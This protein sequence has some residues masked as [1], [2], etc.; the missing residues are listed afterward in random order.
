MKRAP[1]VPMNV[2]FTSPPH[3]GGRSVLAR[4]ATTGWGQSSLCNLR[5]RN[6]G[7]L[8]EVAVI[9]LLDALQRVDLRNRLVVAEVHD[10]RESKSEAAGMP[11]GPLDRVEGNF[12]HDL[13]SDRVPV[14]DVANLHAQELRGHG[15]YLGVSQPG[16]RLPDVDELAHL[17]VQHGERVVGEHALAFAVAPFDRRHDHVERR[18]WTLQLQPRETAASRRVWA[19]RVF[20][21]QAFVAALA[22][23]RKDAVEMV[24]A[25]RLLQAREQEGEL[26]LERLEQAPPFLQRFVEHGPTVDPEQA[27]DDQR[28][29]H[30]APQR[31]GDDLAT[32]AMLQFE[33]T[34]HA[35]VAMR[36]HLAVE[37]DAVRES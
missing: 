10:S 37:H 14:T 17:R 34:K 8:A 16:V 4:S 22:R 7:L 13:W 26:D 28:N 18:E 19:P 33:K 32:E 5:Q 9:Q 25:G 2:S 3:L 36:Q 1:A 11:V 35:P 15:R 23:L 20:D 31:G 29:R 21:H 30:L 27:E 6:L 12:Q 24:G